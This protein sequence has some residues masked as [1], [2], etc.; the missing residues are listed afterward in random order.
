MYHDVKS[1]FHNHSK[2][3]VHVMINLDLVYAL[4]YLV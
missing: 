1:D 4:M 2:L 3:T